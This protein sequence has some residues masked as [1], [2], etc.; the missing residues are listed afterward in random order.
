VQAAAAVF[1][2][3]INIIVYVLLGIVV[4]IVRNRLISV[5]QIL[6]ATMEPALIL[7]IASGVHVLLDI[8]ESTVM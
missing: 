5:L 7:E 2:K 1:K 6:A 4:L 3:E 8:L